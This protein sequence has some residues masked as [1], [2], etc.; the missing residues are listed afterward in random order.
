MNLS[1]G[2][3]HSWRHCYYSEALVSIEETLQQKYKNLIFTEPPYTNGLRIEISN[4][5]NVGPQKAVFEINFGYK[6]SSS[7]EDVDKNPYSTIHFGFTTSNAKP[8]LAVT[9]FDKHLN[10]DEAISLFEDFL[11]KSY[12]ELSGKKLISWFETK[13]EPIPVAKDIHTEPEVQLVAS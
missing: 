2:K 5:E 6:A 1:V 4:P 7:S 9:T 13:I 10:V 12:E 11:G 8:L 3:I